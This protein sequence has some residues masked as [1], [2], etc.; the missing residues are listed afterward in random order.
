MAR[1]KT[2]KKSSK[3]NYDI[4]KHHLVA[5]HS[6]L[7]DRDTKKLLEQYSID[8]EQLPGILITDAAIKKLDPNLDDVIKIERISPTAKIS[9]YYRRVINAK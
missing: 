4:A 8:I 3:K 9:Y 1:K 2:A 7:S 6:K 5:K